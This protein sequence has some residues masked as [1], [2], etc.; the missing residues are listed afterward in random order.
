MEQLPLLS[1]IVEVHDKAAYAQKKYA[2]P[3]T[4]LGKGESSV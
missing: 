3:V 1:N 2:C 4:S